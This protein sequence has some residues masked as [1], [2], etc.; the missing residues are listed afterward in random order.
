MSWSH[1]VNLVGKNI[2]CKERR[3]SWDL[4]GIPNGTRPGGN[5]PLEDAA[6]HRREKREATRLGKLQSHTEE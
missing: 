3:S 2:V 1:R 6:R 4:T 5:I